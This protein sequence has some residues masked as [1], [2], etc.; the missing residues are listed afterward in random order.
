MA[1]AIHWVALAHSV[2]GF[3]YKLVT[4]T[5]KWEDLAHTMPIHITK[6]TTWD[7]PRKTL[8]A[9][10]VAGSVQHQSTDA[11]LTQAASP[12]N[13]PNTPAPGPCLFTFPNNTNTS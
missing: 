4:S 6:T 1:V 7:D 11:L 8:A 10:S 5:A 3:V 12:Q 2:S 13:I 9:Q